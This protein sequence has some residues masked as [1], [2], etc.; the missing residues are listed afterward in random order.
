MCEINSDSS[1]FTVIFYVTAWC[2]H[3]AHFLTSISKQLIA[4]NANKIS[5]S[6]HELK[7]N[8]CNMS[9]CGKHRLLRNKNCTCLDSKHVKS[10]KQIFKGK[11]GATIYPFTYNKCNKTIYQHLSYGTLRNF[12]ATRKAAK[13]HLRYYHNLDKH[14]NKTIEGNDVEESTEIQIA[15]EE[16]FDVNE[17]EKDI[18]NL[19]LLSNLNIE[20]EIC[21]EF[22]KRFNGDKIREYLVTISRDKQFSELQC[23]NLSKVDVSLQL[24][25]SKLCSQSSA[26]EKLELAEII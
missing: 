23:N 22:T 18:K 6:A 16:G 13:C 19:T 4:K 21:R 24:K 15:I 11:D 20:T 2:L 3:D 25:F 14:D 12:H 9:S 5:P 10:N 17:L 26:K 8:S 7:C 1:Q